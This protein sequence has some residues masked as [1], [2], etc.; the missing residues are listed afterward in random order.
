MILAAEMNLKIDV[1][2]KITEYINIWE[3]YYHLGKGRVHLINFFI[4]LLFLTL[5]VWIT[6]EI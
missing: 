4:T 2:Y 6:M 5:Y 1:N 3:K